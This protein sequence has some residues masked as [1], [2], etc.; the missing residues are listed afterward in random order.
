MGGILIGTTP[1]F[2]NFI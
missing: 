1:S 2:K